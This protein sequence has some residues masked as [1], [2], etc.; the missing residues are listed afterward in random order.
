MAR[1][2]LL[3]SGGMAKGAYQI[4]AL[5][6]IRERFAPS[7]IACVSAASIG[8]LNAY[9][10]VH[11]FL[12]DAEQM[13]LSVSEEMDYK[14]FA[15]AMKASV[16]EKLTNHIVKDEPIANRFYVPL[17]DLSTHTLKYV[18]FSTIEADKSIDY[19]SAC[20]TMP[21]Y[22]EGVKVDGANYFD[23]A[24]IDNIPVY[25]LVKEELDYVLCIYFDSSYYMFEN[26]AFNR[27]I[28]RLTFPDNTIISN[29]I[30]LSQDRTQ[31]MLREGYEQTKAILDDVF[32][33]GSD[34]LSYIQDKI[35]ERNGD[36]QNRKI[37]ITGDFIV[38]NINRAAKHF[39]KVEKK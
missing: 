2:G 28:I 11:D 25:P 29:S 32:A 24:M 26:E 18:D 30:V 5:K 4:G 37:R 15:K 10:Y 33:N 1:I 31:Y 38:S 9:A 17:F 20:V 13:W 14:W 35:D 3:L 12:P 19:L 39:V 22:C 21:V 27:K 8:A 34:D 16:I 7:D 6:A 23:G 36:S